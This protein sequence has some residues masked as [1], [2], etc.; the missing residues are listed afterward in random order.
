MPVPGSGGVLA[1]FLLA[2]VSGSL[3]TGW[4]RRF[5][6]HRSVLDIPNERSSH[7]TPTPRGG[8]L[9]I[10][11][12]TLAAV[13]WSGATGGITPQVA[14]GLFGGGLLVAAAGW[15][16]DLRPLRASVRAL[17]QTIAAAWFLL[18][19]GGMP[20]LRFSGDPVSLGPAGGI[21]ALVGI[22]WSVNLYN[23]MDGIDGLAGGQAVIAGGTGAALLLASGSPGLALVAAALAGSSL[24]FLRWNWAPARIF[25]GDVGSGVIGFFFGALAV[26]SERGGG[27]PLAVWLLLGGVFLFDATVTLLRRML[28]GARWYAA[29]R[30]H[31]Y[32]RAI[33][34]GWSH[35]RVCLGAMLL[36]AVCSGLAI[37]VSFHPG[38]FPVALGV[39]LG[40]L[41]LVYIGIE[42]SRPMPMEVRQEV[43]AGAD[44]RARGRDRNR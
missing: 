12:V 2:V 39:A 25:M 5:V 23:F 1:A 16:D 44:D 3:L 36:A 27:P 22:V 26:L 43:A 6:L 14:I 21:L 15:V 35:A 7:T 18:W 10:A 24:G 9:A 37:V 34:L 32:Q 19:A 40:L 28:R 11:L 33:L 31:A 30:S 29:H 38:F 13:L 42:R 20:L 8:G 4:V 17:M 41:G